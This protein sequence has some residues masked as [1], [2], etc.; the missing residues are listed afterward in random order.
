MYKVA[1]RNE[2][3]G[4][5]RVCEMAGEWVGDDY[6][7]SEYWWTEGNFSCDC[8]RGL[9]YDSNGSDSKCGTEKYT[10]LYAELPDGTKIPLDEEPRCVKQGT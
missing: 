2:E 8:N 5:I 4:E 6:G 10:A 3:T 1:I 9:V 7:P